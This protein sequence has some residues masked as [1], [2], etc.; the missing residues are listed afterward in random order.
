M[1]ILRNR[2]QGTE[3]VEE[4]RYQALGIDPECSIKIKLSSSAKPLAAWNG[5]DG[6]GKG[7]LRL[8]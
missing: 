3:I 4:W 8:H 7:D 6:D 1:Q 5:K 2:V